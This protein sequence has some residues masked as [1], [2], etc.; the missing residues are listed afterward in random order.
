MLKPNSI[1]WHA[2][3]MSRGTIFD[4][5]QDLVRY[6]KSDVDI[7]PRCCMKFRDIFLKVQINHVI[8]Y[9]NYRTLLAGDIDRPLPDVDHA[10]FIL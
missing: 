9:I 8:S 3:E 5:K 7:L 6:C 4:L 10:G 1:A 2:D